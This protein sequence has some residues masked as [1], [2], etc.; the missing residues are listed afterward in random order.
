MSKGHMYD[1]VNNGLREQFNATSIAQ[2]NIEIRAFRKEYM[3]S[4]N[5]T[6]EIT[7]TGRPLDGI[8]CPVAPSP[9]TEPLTFKYYNY[10]T[11]V[12]LLDYSSVVVPITKVDKSIDV[13][14]TDFKPLSQTDAEIAADCK[15]FKFF[16][17]FLFFWK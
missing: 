15:Y 2:N 12:N 13:S 8:I 14:Y 3:E 5:R 9:A 16:F 10:T 11:W 17:S 6:K 4:W 1:F 7:G